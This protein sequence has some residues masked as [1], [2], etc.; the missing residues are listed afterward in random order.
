ML[1]NEHEVIDQEKYE[2]LQ[3]TYDLD[4][5]SLD[6]VLSAMEEQGT[7]ER[8]QIKGTKNEAVLFE[9]PFRI[10]TSCEY[11][12]VETT[13]GDE[14]VDDIVEM[15]STAGAAHIVTEHI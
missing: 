6:S 5:P 13:A 4:N 10:A 1:R 3:K 9:C 7:V 8:M 14:D 2:E 15:L 11:Y 12:R